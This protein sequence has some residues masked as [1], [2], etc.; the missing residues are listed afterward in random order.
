MML[1]HGLSGYWLA[2]QEFARARQEAERLCELA[3]QPAERTYLALGRRTLAEV[4]L[5]EHKWAEAEKAVSQA[6]AVLEGIEAP[7]AEWRVCATAAQFYD[8]R[9]RKTKACQ[10]WARSAAVLNQLADSLG[11]AV[12]LRHS[13]LTH[14]SVRVILHRAEV[15]S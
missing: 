12:E 13:L 10:Y 1:S 14:P 15:S 3:V 2:H 4:A 7:L 6:L 5:A 11:E 8:Q 9:H